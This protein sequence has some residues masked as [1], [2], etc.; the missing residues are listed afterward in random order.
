MF[1][2]HYGICVCHSEKRLIVV[3]SGHCLFGNEQKKKKPKHLGKIFPAIRKRSEKRI[4][5]DKKY[6]IARTEHL[7]ENPNCKVQHEECSFEATDIH[8][9]KGRGKY[10]IDKNTFVSVCRSCHTWIETHPYQAKQLGF[11]QSRLKK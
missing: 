7:E 11:S 6:S 8:H 10:Y 5:L 3:K 2:P 1:K 4:E 9:S